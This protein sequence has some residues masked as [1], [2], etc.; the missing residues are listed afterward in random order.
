MNTKWTC[1]NLCIVTIGFAICTT[2]APKA[3][4]E[5]DAREVAVKTD[6]AVQ[7]VAGAND[8]SSM[9][10]ELARIPTPLW[11]GLG[12]TVVLIGFFIYVFLRWNRLVRSDKIDE[13]R[14]SILRF[15]MAFCAASAGGS[16]TGISLI[17]LEKMTATISFGISASAGAGLFVITLL[18]FRPRRPNGTLTANKPNGNDS[19][20]I[21]SAKGDEVSTMKPPRSHVRE[22][23][24]AAFERLH[25][26]LA[27]DH[28]GEFVAIK[29]GELFDSDK[30]KKALRQ[31]ISQRPDRDQILIK[32]VTMTLI[33]EIQLGGPAIVRPVSLGGKLR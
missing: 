20:S 6:Q 14:T 7:G 15:L 18:F 16:I 23:N 22:E 30:D 32:K 8:P 33:G 3:T 28:P 17:Y 19:S 2:A 4:P 25:A 26:I 1:G 21:E 10:G 13:T 31:R 11:I 9:S 29:C 12:F 27:R 5:K 24:G